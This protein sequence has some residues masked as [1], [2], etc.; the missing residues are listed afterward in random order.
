MWRVTATKFFLQSFER[1]KN[2]SKILQGTMGIHRQN[3]GPHLA[4]GRDRP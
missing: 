2:F 4:Q 1:K 3:T